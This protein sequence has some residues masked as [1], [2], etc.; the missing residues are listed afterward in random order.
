MDAVVEVN[1]GEVA[2]VN[3]G[4]DPSHFLR[5]KKGA[6]KIAPGATA[7]IVVRNPDGSV[8]APFSVTKPLE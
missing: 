2:T 8:S 1:G 6:K 3:D 7:T 5:C 4:D